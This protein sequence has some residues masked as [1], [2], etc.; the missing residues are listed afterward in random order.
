LTYQK[1][2]LRRMQPVTRRYAKIL[3]ELSGGIRK[4]KNLTEDIARIE[5]DSEALYQS[6]KYHREAAGTIKEIRMLTADELRTVASIMD[7][8]NLPEGTKHNP[9]MQ[10][11][12]YM[13]EH[14]SG[15][16]SLEVAF[17]AYKGGVNE[18]EPKV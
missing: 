16:I 8:S 9:D 11:R 18:S 17:L 2:T 7:N 4:L 6:Q 13:F 3:N 14:P 12:Q 1:K 10:I 5:M 15:K